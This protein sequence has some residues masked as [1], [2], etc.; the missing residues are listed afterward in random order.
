MNAPPS[1]AISIARDYLLRIT[2]V[3]ARATANKR[4]TKKRINFAGRFDGR[5]GAPV[6]YRAHCP[7]EE[8]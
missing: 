8:V 2:P 3:A 7:I 1:Q 6:Q 4:A 5:G